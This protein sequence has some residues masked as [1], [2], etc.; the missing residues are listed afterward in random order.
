MAGNP[1]AESPGD[2]M[3]TRKLLH[4]SFLGFSVLCVLGLLVTSGL[5]LAMPNEWDYRFGA[6]A[7]RKLCFA[8]F[9][10]GMAIQGFSQMRAKKRGEA[11]VSAPLGVASTLPRPT[12]RPQ[13]RKKRRVK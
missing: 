5:L 7:A 1:P 12:P 6:E 11:E 4:H 9:A 2:T 10:G 3:T 13:R 8:G